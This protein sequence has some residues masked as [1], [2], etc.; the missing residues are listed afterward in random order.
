MTA[1]L[2][3]RP[4]DA[5]LFDYGNTLITVRRPQR[6]LERAYD[7]IAAL[8]RARLGAHVPCGSVLLHAVHDRLEAAVFD[9]DRNGSLE[10][11]NLTAAALDAYADLGVT[12]SE[13][14]L[15]E[16]TRV[17]QTAWWDGI[18]V[19][20]D[21]RPVLET[22][23]AGGVRT[24]I[25]SNAPYHPAT[26]LA[27]LEHLRLAELLDSVTFSSQVGWRKPSPLIF[28]RALAQLGGEAATTVM[29]GDTVSSDIRGAHGAGLRA[30]RLREHSDDQDTSE[31]ADV[32][33]DRL[34]EL[35]RLLNIDGGQGSPSRN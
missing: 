33:I 10:E 28:E 1:S 5:V 16:V 8:L 32:V 2:A 34:A 3:G 30:I 14:D 19:P 29:V 22:L 21:V 23:R 17:E 24:G 11:I 9:H 20:A 25:C 6:S 4:V 31:I 27:Q 35:P 7:S 18:T 15:D 13:A 12:L 26:L